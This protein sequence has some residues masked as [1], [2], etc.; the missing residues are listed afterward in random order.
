MNG[1]TV[2]DAP[3]YS[4]ITENQSTRDE[5]V[6]C[7]Y[8]EHNKKVEFLPINVDKMFP[9][10]EVYIAYECS[11][12]RVTKSNFKNLAKIKILTLSYNKIERIST[13]TF[14]DLVAL[15]DLDLSEFMKIS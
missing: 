4:I 7:L 3:D 13:D 8:F 6:K 10:L 12:S 2:V 11:L 14:E 9:A 1:T 15:I 5:S